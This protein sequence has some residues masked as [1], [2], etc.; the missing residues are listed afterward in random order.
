MHIQVQK[1]FECLRNG[2]WRVLD[3]AQSVEEV[4]GQARASPCPPPSPWR[5]GCR[6]H[7][8]AVPLPGIPRL[9][10]FTKHGGALRR[11][12]DVPPTG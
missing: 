5:T 6:A 10:R 3:A 8:H 1:Q 11:C 12:L 4:H 7:I 9:A 2:S